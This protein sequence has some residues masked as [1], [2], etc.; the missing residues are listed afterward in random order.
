MNRCAF[1]LPALCLFAGACFDRPKGSCTQGEVDCAC[2][3]GLC[4][5]GLVCKAGLCIVDETAVGS[6]DDD[7]TDVKTSDDESS[8]SS[9]STSSSTGVDRV[10]TSD[11]LSTST[12]GSTSTST[13]STGSD[14]LDTSSTSDGTSTSTG[15]VDTTEDT[16]SAST[17]PID[18]CGDGVLDPDEI[19]DSTLGCRDDCTLEHYQCNPLNNAPCGAG[20]KCSSLEIE[21]NGEVVSVTTRCLAF[22]ND[23]PGQLHEGNCYDWTARDEWCDLGLACALG[24]VTDACA[25]TNCCVEYCDLTDPNFVCAFEGDACVPYFYGAVP[26]GF[27]HLGFCARP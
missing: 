4:Q 18:T 20:F 8:E 17:G 9:T 21:E 1:A 2:A 19:C 6:S 13:G 15:D 25:D 11:A 5:E 26:P 22:V 27:D 10:T 3:N 7:T 14:A 16:G 12:S 24:R 23:P